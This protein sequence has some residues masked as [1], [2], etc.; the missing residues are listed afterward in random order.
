MNLEAIINEIKE[1]AVECVWREREECKNISDSVIE[2]YLR[3]LL[4]ERDFEIFLRYK[5]LMIEAFRE[6]VKEELEFLNDK[7]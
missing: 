7:F 5:R 2:N 3:T 1:F 4:S 6:A